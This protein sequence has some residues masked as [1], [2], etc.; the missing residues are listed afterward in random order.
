V[1]HP[2]DDHRVGRRLAPRGVRSLGFAAGQRAERGGGGRAHE[3][4]PADSGVDS[5]L[6]ASE[7]G[8]FGEW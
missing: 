3:A 8:I 4:A 2:E 7:M 5:A 6:F 1:S